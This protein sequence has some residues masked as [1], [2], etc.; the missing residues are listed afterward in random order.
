M[1]F[2]VHCIKSTCLGMENFF[3]VWLTFLASLAMIRQIPLPRVLVLHN[4]VWLV[5]RFNICQRIVWRNIF[6]SKYRNQCSSVFHNAYWG[7]AYNALRHQWEET[8]FA[9]WC[10]IWKLCWRRR[11]P[12]VETPAASTDMLFK[13]F[14]EKVEYKGL[15]PSL[16]TH[17][18][19]DAVVPEATCLDK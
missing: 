19:A 10:K 12:T 6:L 15:L 13:S 9:G 1:L 7:C 11:D 3:D 14:Y 17:L 18:R 16:L 8:S 2:G 5:V 4:C